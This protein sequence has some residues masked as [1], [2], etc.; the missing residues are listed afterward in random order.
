[1]SW[2]E[3]QGV[4]IY[5]EISGY[6]DPIIFFS[7]VGGGSWSWY[8][9]LPYFCKK[10]EVIVFDNRGAGKSDKPKNPYSMEDFAQDGALILDKLGIWKAF[11]VGISMGGMIAQVFALKYPD[12][13]KG[14]VLGATHC[15]GSIK[16]SPDPEVLACFMDNE[17]LSDDEILDKNT[18]IL[19]SAGFLLKKPDEVEEYKRV[20]REAGIQPQYALEN[21]LIAIR[22][23]SCC[24]EIHKISA[25]TLIITGNDDIL[26]PPENSRILHDRIPDSKLILLPDVGHA[27]HVEAA[28]EFNRIVD[29]FFGSV[30]E[31]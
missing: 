25:P 19:F 6:G 31:N 12:R 15:G 30:K 16:I 4:K 21:Q 8:R 7:G 26:V 10:Y 13:V 24:H 18:R 11:V 28:D 27:I 5:Y 23:F 2:I 14:L 3:N 29:E 17:G 22:N 20:H 1:M 9:Q